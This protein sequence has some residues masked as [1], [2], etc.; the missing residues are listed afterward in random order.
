MGN[1]FGTE[2]T[3]TMDMFLANP[4]GAV[5]KGVAIKPGN[6]ELTKGVVLV[7]DASTGLY[8]PATAATLIAGSICC[9]LAEDVNT[10]TGV[11]GPTYQKS[12]YFRGHFLRGKVKLANGPLPAAALG[13]LNG[14]GIMLE[15]YVPATGAETVLK[16]ATVATPMATPGA[17]AVASGT[18]VELSTETEGAD[19]YYTTN[20]STPTTSSTKYTEPIEVT[21]AVT[22]KAIA[23]R[24]DMF[25]SPVLTAAYTI[26]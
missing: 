14:M 1:L 19:I 25:D 7:R 6:G 23:V 22:I 17:G 16:N 26:A 10:G 3:K 21:A 8:E 5:I 11:T 18:K 20:G 2:G 4:V 15:D 9:V 13:V 12:A 24:D